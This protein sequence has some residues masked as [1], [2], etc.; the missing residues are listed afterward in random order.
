MTLAIAQSSRQVD[1]GAWDWS[2]WLTG[3][4]AELAAVRSVTW[5][6]HETFSEP[7]RH[8]TDAAGGFR[9]DAH[10]WG[11][12]RVWATVQRTNGVTVALQHWLRL[13]DDVRGE[14]SPSRSARSGDRVFLSHSAV[15]KPVADEVRA[16]LVADGFDVVTA[17]AALGPGGDWKLELGRLLESCERVVGVVSESTSPWVERELELAA[18][19][20]HPVTVVGV[21]A[22]LPG[23]A[24]A[25]LAVEPDVA[26]HDL[27]PALRH[28]FEA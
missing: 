26:A 23:W 9:L 18:E 13:G 11:E 1:E 15:D 24:H 4:P 12:F 5:Q 6:L 19:L 2:V 7:V 16:A 14:Q 28:R 10:G 25:D 20:D 22:S 8:S 17:D 3:E 21:G 27:A